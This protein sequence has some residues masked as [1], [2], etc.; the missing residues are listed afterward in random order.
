MGLY[1]TVH[2]PCPKCGE[3]QGFQSK[4]GPCLLDDFELDKCPED[5][6]RDVNRHA[7]AT[8]GKCGI[9][10]WVGS[11]TITVVMPVSAVWP[12]EKS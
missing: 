1:D 6:L 12:E 5:V 11:R 10:F 2:V 4:S 7:P 3:K 8:C 9:K